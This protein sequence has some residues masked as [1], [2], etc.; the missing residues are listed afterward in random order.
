M[1]FQ[2]ESASAAPPP[3]DG[4]VRHLEGFLRSGQETGEFRPFATRP[5]AI[6]IR[7]AVDAAGGRIADPGFDIDSY[8]TELVTMVDR[9]TRKN[10]S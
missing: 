7:A 8:T 10:P 6:A 9:A 4:L 3:A 1:Y 2:P 5:M